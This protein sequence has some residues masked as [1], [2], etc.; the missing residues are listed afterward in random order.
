VLVS[1][2]IFYV[3]SC[4]FFVDYRYLAFAVGK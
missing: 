1:T 2:R 4:V 3:D